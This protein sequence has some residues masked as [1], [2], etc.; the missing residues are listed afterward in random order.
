MRSHTDAMTDREAAW[1]VVHEALVSRVPGPAR[2]L[3]T[4]C[5]LGAALGEPCPLLRG[6]RLGRPMPVP[7]PELPPDPPLDGRRRATP[8]TTE[9]MTP[10]TIASVNRATSQV[11]LWGVDC[12]A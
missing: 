9:A 7:L 5:Q 4:H 1:D 10:I 12:G 11:W 8:T 3:Q 6:G 2:Q